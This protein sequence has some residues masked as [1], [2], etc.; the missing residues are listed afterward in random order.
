VEH[1]SK[2]VLQD[3]MHF[4]GY[5]GDSYVADL[6]AE[7]HVGGAGLGAQP[8]PLLLMSLAGCTAMDVISIL[9]KKRQ[10]VTALEVDVTGDAAED[11]PKVFK[12]IRVRYV[13]TGKGVDP[14]AVQRAI[15]LSVERYCPVI[16]MLKHVVPIEFSFDII[17]G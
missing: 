1:T 10:E 11:Y 9:R 3:G 8:K 17:E 5:V 15:D 4:K 6:D 13:I 12:H 14:A 16:N 7:E 2:V